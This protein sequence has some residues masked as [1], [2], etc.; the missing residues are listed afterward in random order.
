MA[1]YLKILSLYFLFSILISAQTRQIQFE[2]LSVKEGLSATTVLSILPDSRG[3]LWIGTYDGLNRYDGYSF[4]TFK[5]NAN[6]STTLS[7]NKIRAISEDSSGFIWIGTWS[8]GLNKYDREKEEYVV[9]EVNG[10]PAFATPEQEKQGLNF[11]NKKIEKIVDLIDKKT[12][13][14]NK[15]GKK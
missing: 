11:N 12:A 2:H 3:F 10:I 7:G 8:S 4:T 13:K 14:K 6:D 9:L 1:G 15:K 5:H